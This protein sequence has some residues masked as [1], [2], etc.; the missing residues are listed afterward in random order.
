[1]N[2]VK[3]ELNEGI[4]IFPGGQKKFLKS[5]FTKKG[6]NVNYALKT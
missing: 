6:R 3:H 4:K 2:A 5:N 1:M